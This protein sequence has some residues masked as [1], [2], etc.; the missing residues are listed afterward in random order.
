VST[1]RK[2]LPKVEIWSGNQWKILEPKSEMELEFESAGLQKIR[3][4]LTEGGLT[5]NQNIFVEVK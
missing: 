5:V 3:L 1:N 2:T 4:K